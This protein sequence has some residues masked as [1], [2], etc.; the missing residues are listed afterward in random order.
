MPISVPSADE[1]RQMI[2]E[3]REKHLLRGSTKL[4]ASPMS[5][6]AVA[7]DEDVDRVD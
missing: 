3:L 2:Q 5:V 4:P 1:T 6:A 7:V